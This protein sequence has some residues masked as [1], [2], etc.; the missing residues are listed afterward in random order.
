MKYEFWVFVFDEFNGLDIFT[1]K[2][3]RLLKIREKF[4]DQNGGLILKQQLSPTESS[5]IFSADELKTATN[6]Y[7]EDRILG[8]GGFGTV[9]KG[10]LKDGRIVA[11][12]KP[13][14]GDQ[15]KSQIQEFINEV[16]ILMQTNHKNVV[17]ILGCCLETKV[18]VLVYEF[19]SNGTLLENIKKGE[20]S[21]LNWENCIRVATE[22]VDAL[23]Y[24]HSAAVTPIIHRDIK[25][26]NILLDDNYTA[27]IAD[28]GASMLAPIG[29]T[30]ESTDHLLGTF[31]YMDPESLHTG[32]LTEKS[33]V[34]SFGVV[35]AELL[36]KE[37]V[38]SLERA[39]EQASL[40]MYFV[41]SMKRNCL[42]NILDPQLVIEASEEQL[43]SVS[44]LVMRC[45]DIDS[46]NRPTMREIAFELD[47][48]KKK[49]NH[50]WMADKQSYD[51]TTS[52]VGQQQDDLYPTSSIGFNSSNV[53]FS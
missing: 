33:D 6:N 41:S 44:N 17:K 52:L 34:Y 53:D 8:K 20:K 37:K 46:E 16:V 7:S 36:T 47:G 23:A 38:I 27:K 21:W 10:T 50:P 14:M 19:I 15:D 9:Y 24:L 51:E 12:K 30:L 3:R 48:L 13:K 28:F 26:A 11:I 4:F 49:P 22:V 45:I 5:K 35:L 40:A 18:P 2:R 25:S 32:R 1:M 29:Q 42:F 31:G 39:P 43:L